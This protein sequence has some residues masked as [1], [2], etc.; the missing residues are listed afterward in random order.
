MPEIKARQICE[1][2]LR[3]I[4]VAAAEQRIDAFMAQT[5]LE[6]LNV[7][8]ESWALERLW[9]PTRSQVPLTLV[10]GQATYTWGET[11]PPADIP[12]AP[13]TRLEQALLTVDTLAPG[14]EWPIE[15]LDQTEYQAGIWQ[16]ALASSYPAAVYLNPTVPV[17][18][19]SV[20]PVPTQAYTLQ[21]FA[22][23]HSAPYL[24]WD[25]VLS[26]PVG[27]QRPM[28]YGLAVDLGPQYDIEASPTVHRIAEESKR[29]IFP[30]NVEV[31]RL[32]L[33]PGRPRG[34]TPYGYPRAFY[35]GR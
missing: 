27:Y 20:W 32:S 24:H 4:G 10:P 17:Y 14:L 33:T 12:Y 7:L 30:I 6:A 13:P 25:H 15:V 31:G 5:A 29:A 21:L 28:I 8:L 3:L 1:P 19:L 34:G 2:A 23:M 9:T 11:V 16:K 18:Q 35:T 26:W 22:W